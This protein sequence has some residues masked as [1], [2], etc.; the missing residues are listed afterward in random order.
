[1]QRQRRV[2]SHFHRTTLSGS[3]PGRTF[4]TRV[5]QG[6]WVKRFER[7]CVC[8]C[9]HARILHI[10]TQTMLKKNTQMQGIKSKGRSQTRAQ[11]MDEKQR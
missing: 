9:V 1:M 5:S 4:V 7:T 3:G 11:V 8:V 6:L 10:T 2:H